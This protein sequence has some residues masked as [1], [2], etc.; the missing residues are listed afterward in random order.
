MP[1]VSLVTSH[2]SQTLHGGGDERVL[3]LLAR[4]GVPW[5][6][7]SIYAVPRDGSTP[8]LR[9]CLDERLRDLEDVAELRVYFNRNVNPFTF[10]LGDMAGVD[11]AD[12]AEAAT[13]YVYQRLDNEQ[14]TA[15]ALLKRLSP[16]EC[17]TAV[18]AR[19]EETIRTVVPAGSDVVVGVSGG[20]DSNALL[21]AL[22]QLREHGV[23]IHPLIVKG[24]PDW[25]AGV[26]RAQELCDG[27]GLELTVVEESDA[28]ALL[29]IPP[30]DVPLIDRFER[31]FGGDD[32]EF[33]GT[34]LIRLA[35]SAHARAVG[36]EHICTGLNLEDVL[37]EAIFRLSNGLRPAPFP[38]RRIGDVTLTMPLWLCPKRI[39]DGC[40]PRWSLENYDARYPCFS[41]GRNLYYSVVWGLQS[42]FP[43]FPERLARGLSEL[44]EHDP[45]TYQL[46]E[47]LGFH[48]ERFVPFPLRRKFERML[49]AGVAAG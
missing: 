19:V 29:G 42:Q 14:G 25:D 20:G 2:G 1:V 31:E 44:A 22:G 49:G 11:S 46:D 9:P 35:L 39:I 8:L 26:P 24:I 33:L 7:V 10:A 23:R 12:P 3:E 34:L 45:V 27:Y 21:D 15:Q 17:R 30:D 38:A 5:S 16:Q 36:T 32:F 6:A 18:A 43:G 13:E 47:Q 4:H 37:C 28:K 40:F 41:L 48:V